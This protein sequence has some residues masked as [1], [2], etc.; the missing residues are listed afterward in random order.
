MAVDHLSV[1]DALRSPQVFGA[2]PAF[3]DLSSWSAWLTFLKATNGLPLTMEERTIYERHTGRGTYH[4][5][6]GGFAESVAIVGVQSGK[7]QVAAILADHAALTG[8]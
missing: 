4:P 1:V 3:R 2:L 7:S 8:E 5:P 6:T